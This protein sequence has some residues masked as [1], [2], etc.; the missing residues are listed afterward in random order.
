LSCPLPCSYFPDLRA[1]TQR[2]KLSLLMVMTSHLSL[3]LPNLPVI[4][5]C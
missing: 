5:R 4:L 1:S 3:D 2:S